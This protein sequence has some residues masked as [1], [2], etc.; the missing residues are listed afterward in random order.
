MT[1]SESNGF[2]STGAGKRA[3]EKP[4][5]R[6]PKARQAHLRMVQ[7]AR[8]RAEHLRV[9]IEQRLL[10]QAEKARRRYKGR[11][12]HEPMTSEDVVD[13]VR[14]LLGV[15]SATVMALLAPYDERQ[16]LLIDDDELR[17]IMDADSITHE[18]V[19]LASVA[20]EPPDP[21]FD[22]FLRAIL[23]PPA[24]WTSDQRYIVTIWGARLHDIANDV[25]KLAL[26][27][28]EDGGCDLYPYDLLQGLRE[29]VV[30][31]NAPRRGGSDD[32][33]R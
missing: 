2:G 20:S 16:A 12:A 26:R 10:E 4:R 24:S 22:A 5:R 7:A 25:R 32:D 15:S 21:E 19:H 30:R 11:K 18:W 8:V 14:F 13:E 31:M 28:S 9:A 3:S 29:Q 17:C 27:L 33:G 23:E 1:T 6:S